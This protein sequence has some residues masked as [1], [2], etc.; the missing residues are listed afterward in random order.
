MLHQGEVIAVAFSPDGQAVLTAGADRTARLWDAACGQPIGQ[1][2]VL[3]DQAASVAIAFGPDG[4]SILTASATRTTRLWDAVTGE[5]RGRPLPDSGE[6]GAV[7]I[8][9]D[10]QTVLTFGYHNVARLWDAAS[11]RPIGSPLEHRQAVTAAAFSPDGAVTLTGSDDR[12]ARLWDTATGRPIGDPL[13]HGGEV[14][15]VAFRPDGR[16]FFTG[17]ADK[18][19]RF[20][21]TAT[22]RPVGRPLTFPDP[23]RAVAFGPGGPIVLTEGEGHEARLWDG[24]TGRPIGKPM[25]HLREFRAVAF[26]PDG[27]TI[28]TGGSDQVVRLWDVATALPIGQPMEQGE[29]VMAA[30]FS[31][32]GRTILTSGFDWDSL[33]RWE[34]PAPL[35]TD[36]PRLT[37]W[38][39]A[40]TGLELDEQ[41]SVR[42]LDPEARRRW[43]ERLAQLGGPPRE[44]ARLLDPILFGPQP[45]ARAD[46]LAKLGRWAEAEAVFD[47]ALT[48]R[49][50]SRVVRMA[51]CRFDFLRSDPGRAAADLGELVRVVPEDGRVRYF[52]ILSLSAAGDRDGLRRAIAELLDRFRDTTDPGMA[53]DVAWWCCCLAPDAVD[54][55]EAPVRLAE[56]ALQGTT[57]TG[58]ATVLNTLGAALY[59]AGRYDEAIRRLQ[60]GIQLRGGKS[61]PQDW[62]FLAMA[63]FR[64]GHRDEARRWVDR[65]RDRPPVADSAR[66]WDELEIRL[67]RSEAEAVILYDPAFPDDPFAP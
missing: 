52:R 4:R 3:G 44:P 61:E 46:G 10:G 36:L 33:R 15:A 14:R 34:A 22:H 23:V 40:I 19:A 55:P 67:L 59:R 50:S 54:A 57:G 62:A 1:P 25:K 6:I 42:T 16:T 64:Q 12:T 28:L 2:L 65:F 5:P 18:T 45:T 43:R 51:R 24:E 31:P 58:K 35:P 13:E 47:A 32:D 7:A 53:N 20:W 38:V 9:P 27:R 63:H 17:G 21:D 66:F 29:P 48:A 39:Q 30:A 26:G 60:E 37:A 11:S 8:S 41:G 56:I 49:P